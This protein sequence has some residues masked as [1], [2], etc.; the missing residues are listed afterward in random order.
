MRRKDAEEAEARRLRAE[1]MSVGAIAKRLS[2]AKSSV[3]VW[4]RDVAPPRPAPKPPSPPGRPR[5]KV[6]DVPGGPTKRC[7]RCGLVLPVTAFNRAGGGRQHWCRD[8]FSVYFR[9]RGDKHR[10][11]SSAARKRRQDRARAF[12]LDDLRAHPCVDCGEDEILVL[13]FDHHRGEKVAA[14]AHLLH[15]GAKLAR[16]EDEVQ[17]CEVVCVNCHRRR[18]ARRAG[19]FRATGVPPASWT[20]GARRNAELTLTVLRR[21]GCVDCGEGDPVVLDFDHRRDKREHVPRLANFGYSVSTLEAEIAKCDVRC[22]N[23]HRIRTLGGRGCW[24]EEDHWTAA[25][26]SNPEN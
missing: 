6:V 2:V 18:T 11:Q 9:E 7:G 12:L 3:S 20:A 14:L 1:G 19:Y 5:T 24:R 8:C 21:S 15:S 25:L 22:A 26:H 13:E 4:T 17:R 23:C 16:F 10:E